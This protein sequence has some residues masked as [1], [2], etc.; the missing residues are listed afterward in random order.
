MGLISLVVEGL[1][2]APRAEGNPLDERYWM[3]A[4][5][6]LA[7]AVG[8]QLT[9]KVALQSSCVFQ[10]V[11]LYAETT[12]GLPIKF[13]RRRKDGGRE[14]VEDH[15]LL[16][17]L[18]GDGAPNAWQTGLEFRET[19]TAR[20]VLWGNAYARILHASAG[21]PEQMIPLD[22]ERCTLEQL[23]NL[24]LRLRHR[25]ADGTEETFVQEEFFRIQGLGVSQ[26]VGEN[27]LRLSREAVALWLGM[28][29]F[30]GLFFG[31]GAKP[32]VYLQHP[33]Q[34]SE[35]AYKRL[36]ESLIPEMSG[37]RNMHK[38]E[39]LEEGMKAESVGF[40]A[41]EAQMTESREAQVREVARW[42]NVAEHMLRA[43]KQPTFASIEQF[44]REFIDYS[45]KPWL[46]RWET[47][48]GRWLI[49][50]P[51]VFCRHN[52]DALLR[53]HT[54]ERAAA[55]AKYVESGI[56]TRN[57]VRIE[58]DLNPLPGLDDPLTPLN[59]GRGDEKS[60][61]PAHTPPPEEP[62]EEDEE[63]RTPAPAQEPSAAPPAVL[64]P[65]RFRLIAESAA[66][67]V[68]RKEISRVAERAPKLASKP[69]AWSSWVTE[70]YDEHAALVSDRLQLEPAVARAYCDR[71][72]DELLAS[73]VAVLETWQTT[74]PAELSALV[75]EEPVHA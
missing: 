57:E 53:G 14:V 4:W 22:P 17:L 60:E 73:S 46:R 19:M 1:R 12:G 32:S 75:L 70:F 43:G 35:V 36:K 23:P 29:K 21:Y 10:A 30:A 15:P 6:D 64:A 59:M 63:A 26:Q 65:R 66:A 11:R 55:Q 44:A 61:P 25:R 20:A 31:Q 51:D 52:V 62:P 38:A 54:A 2:G 58:E 74:A 45:L 27:V 39:I 68:V 71:H 67:A 16:E 72:R 50:E 40:N 47:S 7:N 37:L 9:P 56:K 42:F 33:S 3:G 41:Q 8:I 49:I 34:L 28:E 24:R 48:I 5:G 18:D 13:Y 69:E